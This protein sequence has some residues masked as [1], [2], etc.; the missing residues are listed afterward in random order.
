[1]KKRL[2]K[3]EQQIL[4][5]SVD[6]STGAPVTAASQI[7]RAALEKELYQF[8]NTLAGFDIGELKDNGSGQANLLNTELKPQITAAIANTQK[9][10]PG[11]N[12]WLPLATSIQR[13]KSIRTYS[14]GSGS[15]KGPGETPT[16]YKQ[17]GKT[18]VDGQPYNPTNPAHIAAVQALGIDPKT[19]K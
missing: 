5:K 3:N 17:A 11:A 10:N 4:L 15:K 1:M 7:D 2:A 19:I 16:V 14:A 12:V 8:L 6:K 18:M 13:A 9:P